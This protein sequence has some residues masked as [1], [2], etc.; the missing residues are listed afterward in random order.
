[1]R[2]DG[3]V[4]TLAALAVLLIIVFGVLSARSLALA[5]VRLAYEG[6]PPL[7]A[8]WNPPPDD[9]QAEWRVSEGIVPPPHANA[10][11][12]ELLGWARKHYPATTLR[13]DWVAQRDPNELDLGG[14]PPRRL[15]VLPEIGLVARVPEGRE[16][17]PRPNPLR[18]PAVETDRD[19]D[20]EPDGDRP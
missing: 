8:R 9:S 7:S 16:G 6:A 1:M 12:D 4:V 17:R 5:P 11:R 19:R 18:S 13:V 3:V 20:R 14:G 10:T 15:Y 2:R